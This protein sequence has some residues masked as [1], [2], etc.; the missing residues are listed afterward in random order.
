MAMRNL[1]RLSELSSEILDKILGLLSIQE[2]ARM[3]ILS[4]FWREMWFNLRDLNFNC[5][6]FYDIEKKYSSAHS[7]FRAQTSKTETINSDILTSAG[8]Y[9]VN[10]VLIEH[11]GHIRK[12]GFSFFH[13]GRSSLTSRSFDIDQ[14]LLLITRKGVEVIDIRFQRDGKDEYSLPKC[15]FSCPTLKRLWLHGVSVEPL[16]MPCILP[17]ATSLSFVNVKFDPND[18]L[19]YRV[20]VPMLE[21]LLFIGCA[22]M[23]SFNITAP[24]LCELQI[25]SWYDQCGGFLPVHLDMATVSTLILDALSLKKFVEEFANSPLQLQPHELNVENLCLTN[26]Y[27]EDD[28]SSAFIRLLKLCPKSRDIHMDMAFVE[29]MRDCLGTT[30]NSKELHRVAETRNLLHTLSIDFFDACENYPALIKGLVSSFPTLVKFVINDLDSEFNQK[31]LEF[32]TNVEMKVV[33]FGIE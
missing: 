28:A 16:N 25:H 20:N 13:H 10:K 12:F 4:T 26:P 24:K 23:F 21:R 7:D 27:D 2:A 31:I 19:D 18:A 32:P 17:N 14:W 11:K 33:N 6:F 8:M 22:N 15:I 5:L 1:D 9:V 29:A 30:E 3:A